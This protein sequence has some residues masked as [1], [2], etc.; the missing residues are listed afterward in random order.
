MTRLQV[1]FSARRWRM[2]LTHV[3]G[4]LVMQ[5]IV[6]LATGSSWAGA[7]WV[8]AWYWGRETAQYQMRVKAKGQSTIT[9]ALR[10][11]LPWQWGRD[12]AID[13]I[14]P[15]VAVMIAPIMRAV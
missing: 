12:S 3:L 11:L 10:G 8:V 15:S 13:L 6:T 1:W 14:L 9:V 7:L 4:G 2:S 5:A